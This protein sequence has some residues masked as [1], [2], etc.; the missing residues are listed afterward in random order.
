MPCNKLAV[1][2]AVANTDLNVLFDGDKTKIA[3]AVQAV[4]AKALGLTANRIYVDWDGGTLTVGAGG[5]TYTLTRTGVKAS[6]SGYSLQS[7]TTKLAAALKAL[8]GMVTQAK[9]AAALRAKYQIVE[10]R[11]LPTGQMVLTLEV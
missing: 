10:E 1:I 2:T 4:T 8:C 9:V 3:Q 7:D 11:R 6:G 5:A